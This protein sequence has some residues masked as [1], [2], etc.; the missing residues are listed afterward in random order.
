M[1]NG[2]LYFKEV[3]DFVDEN[4]HDARSQST[5]AA[6][7]PAPTALERAASLTLAIERPGV[8]PG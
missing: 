5:T 7:S 8:L 3:I 2:G 4:N 1:I 6:T